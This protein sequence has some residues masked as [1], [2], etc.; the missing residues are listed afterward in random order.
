MPNHPWL[1]GLGRVLEPLLFP[2][3]WVPFLLVNN[4]PGAHMC[5]FSETPALSG[6]LALPNLFFKPAR[7]L[8]S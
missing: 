3:F 1:C 2:I 4:T 6:S 7:S 5:C 8:H